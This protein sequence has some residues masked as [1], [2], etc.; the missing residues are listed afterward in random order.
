MSAFALGADKAETGRSPAL[1]KHLLLLNFRARYAGV[2]VTRTPMLS[3]SYNSTRFGALHLKL[4]AWLYAKKIDD[5]GPHNGGHHT[6]RCS[7]AV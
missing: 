2:M 6:Q 4:F 1:R 7:N 5:R 3:T